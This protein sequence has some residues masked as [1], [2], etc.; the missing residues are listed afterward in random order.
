MRKFTISLGV[1]GILAMSGHMA[2][3]GTVYSN[4][5]SSNSNGFTTGNIVT[6]PSNTAKFLGSFAQGGIPSTTLNL[7]SLQPFTTGTLS[8][9]ID[10]ILS[11]DGDGQLGFGRDAF[12]VSGTGLTT[13][14]HD[15]ANYPGNS[16]DYPVINSLPGTGSDPT[17]T[18][19]FGYEF[20]NNPT[21]NDTVYHIT[22]PFTASGTS[23][24]FTFAANTSE[25]VSNEFYGID[26]VVVTTDAVPPVPEPASMTL[27]G[28]SL[29]AFGAM[30][31]RR[32]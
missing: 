14:D 31:R 16:Q 30:R 12:I 17:L 26:N 18:N 23:L 27:L 2:P 24:S 25:D 4:D 32:G 10:V 1:V 22:L 7:S 21:I 8:F 11:M 29:L 20:D 9:D 28:A 13:F 19:T 5:F 15:F 3:A 6:S